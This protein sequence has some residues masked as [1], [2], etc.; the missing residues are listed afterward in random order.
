MP[1]KLPLNTKT[2]AINHNIDWCISPVGSIYIAKNDI[3]IA[4][5]IHTIHMIYWI[6]SFKLCDILFFLYNSRWVPY[7]STHPLLVAIEICE[8]VS[9]ARLVDPNDN[10]CCS[11]V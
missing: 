7:L 6:H 8:E 9:L 2:C 4:P 1:I 11:S 3:T 5:N 10:T